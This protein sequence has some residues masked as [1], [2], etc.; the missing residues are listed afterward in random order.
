MMFQQPVTEHLPQDIVAELRQRG[1]DEQ[2]L[3]NQCFRQRDKQKI[4]SLQSNEA[5]FR[6]NAKHGEY[7]QFARF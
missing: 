4:L 2:I 3:L 1:V 7:V 5:F 6:F